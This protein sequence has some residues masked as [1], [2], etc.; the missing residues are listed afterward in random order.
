MIFEV[1]DL[2]VSAPLDPAKGKRYIELARGNDMDNLYN[3]IM[4]MDDYFNP[5]ADGVLSWRSISLCAS[6]SE[7]GL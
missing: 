7:E 3:M 5:T 1:E 6:D 4:Q 2:K